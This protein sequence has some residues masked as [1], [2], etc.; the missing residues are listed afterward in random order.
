MEKIFSYFFGVKK[1]RKLIH[2][3]LQKPQNIFLKTEFFS[4]VKILLGD[5]CFFFHVIFLKC[6]EKLFFGL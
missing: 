3:H 2:V 5:E 1:V 4:I 6:R